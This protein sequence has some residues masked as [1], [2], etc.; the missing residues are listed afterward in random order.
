MN[1]LTLASQINHLG[2]VAHATKL[3]E[4]KKLA[5]NFVSKNLYGKFHMQNI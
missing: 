4:K 2:A 3:L 5:A 1:P